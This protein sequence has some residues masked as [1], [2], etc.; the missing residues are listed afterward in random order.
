MPKCSCYHEYPNEMKKRKNGKW[1]CV[2]KY[3]C[4]RNIETKDLGEGMF[5]KIIH[6]T[7]CEYGGDQND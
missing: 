3:H 6:K 5:P 1:I 4:V 7:Y 2:D